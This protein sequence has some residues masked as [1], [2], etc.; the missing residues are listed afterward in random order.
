MIARHFESGRWIEIL[1]KE[2]LITSVTPCDGPSDGLG[3]KD[4][5][6]PA[7]WDIQVNGRCGVSFSDPTLTEDQVAAI[8]RAQVRLGTSRLC[9]TLITAPP[10]DMLHGV[11]TIARACERFPDVGRMVLGIHLEG[12]AISELDGF[13]GA[14][15]VGSVRDPD[16]DEF[17]ALREASGDRIAIITLAPERRD[18]IAFI[19]RATSEGVVVALGHTAADTSTIRAAVEA[20]ASLSTHLGNG[21]ASPLH[22][23]PNPI[24]D[25]AAEDGLM[26]SLIADGHHLGPA[27]LRTLVRAKTPGR[28]MLVSDASPLAGLPAG[29]YGDWE[30]EPSGRIVLAGTSY[31]AGANRGIETSVNHLLRFAGLTLDQ[32][33][34]AASTNPARLLS[35]RRD[36][37][38]HE[39]KPEIEV[40]SVA[41]LIKFRLSLTSGDADELTDSQ[42]LTQDD[43]PRSSD[44]VDDS[45]FI[46]LATCVDG[47]WS[48]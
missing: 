30:V 33:I 15:P 23:H 48:E 2:D 11:R 25:Q 40:G 26:A 31:L 44:G 39:P 27:I 38:L 3:L 7:F 21:I 9:P 35:G 13:R 43:R 19:R 42:G 14:H 41:N 17:L 29:R 36:D 24:W 1:I 45:R 18:A 8:V 46:L 10:L 4:W 6:A 28:I 37:D 12:P 16:W 32:A 5:V 20:G 47:S 34:H 22:R